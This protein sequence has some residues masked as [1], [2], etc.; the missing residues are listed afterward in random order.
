VG[1][2]GLVNVGTTG[3]DR[4]LICGVEIMKGGGICNDCGGAPNQGRC[5][6]NGQAYCEPAAGFTGQTAYD[7]FG[8]NIALPIK[9]LDFTAS[10]T[11]E[12]VKLD[13]TTSM[14]ENFSKFIVERSND[15]LN[16]QA[17][18]EQPG[19]GFNIY[20]IVS[21]YSYEDDAPLLGFNY[22]RLKAVDLD[23][24]FEYFGM[25]AVKFTGGKKL[26]IYPNPS[27]GEVVSFRT[28]F[29]PEESDRIVLTDQLG[30][31]FFN[32]RISTIRSSIS[33]QYKLPA[34]I[35]LLRYISND[36]EQTA[37]VVVRD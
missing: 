21:K 8:Y 14:E 35:Y 24:S 27:S 25:K 18:G 4:L 20:D 11:A 9:L 10:I 17:I 28:N 22:Y 31:E 16:F 7:Q 32:S 36:F 23:E 6:Y 34:G 3:S 5:A 19:K 1:Q 2:G 30:I 29:S 26:A 12:K 33:F 15:G 13:W 37:R